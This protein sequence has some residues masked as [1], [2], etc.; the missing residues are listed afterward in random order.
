MH[1]RSVCICQ[2]REQWIEEKK[3][4]EEEKKRGDN[5]NGKT[6]RVKFKLNGINEWRRGHIISTAHKHSLTHMK[7]H[8][9]KNT[10]TAAA[11][12][13]AGIRCLCLFN[14]WRLDG[15]SPFFPIE[16]FLMPFPCARVCARSRSRHFL[17]FSSHFISLV[18]SHLITK[19]IHVMQ[20]KH[21]QQQQQNGIR[22]S[23]NQILD[24]KRLKATSFA[25]S[26]Q[27]ITAAQQHK[28]RRRRGRRKIRKKGIQRIPFL[29]SA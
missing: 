18:L 9:R 26:I 21:Q 23:I 25:T 6:I 20:Y 14:G 5:V 27:T 15:Q 1:T 8:G 24:N 16:C 2:M 7:G 29:L 17:F 22:I 19:R 13:I 28:N 11:K 3:R 10:T 12:K 4:G